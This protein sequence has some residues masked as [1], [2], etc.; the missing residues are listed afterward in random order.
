MQSPRPNTRNAESILKDLSYKR[1]NLFKVFNEKF[2]NTFDILSQKHVFDTNETR[3]VIEAINDKT[4]KE[5][6]G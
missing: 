5:F 4:M 1:D 3:N 6:L 2:D